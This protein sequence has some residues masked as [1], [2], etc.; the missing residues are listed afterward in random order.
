MANTVFGQEVLSGSTDGKPV[1]VVATSSPGTTIHTAQASA[2]LVDQVFLY[3]FCFHSAAVTLHIEF[4]G[5][6]STETFVVTVQ[7][8]QPLQLV[9]SGLPLRNSLVVKAWASVANVT[10]LSGWVYRASA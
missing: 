9:V 6:T 7:P 4:G 2:S 1:L 5:T 3:A 8:N 10:T